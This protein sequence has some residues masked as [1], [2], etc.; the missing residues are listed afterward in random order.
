M[1]FESAADCNLE[2]KNGM[3]AVKQQAARKMV[4][5]VRKNATAQFNRTGKYAGGWI[6]EFEGDDVVVY[7]KGERDSLSHLLENGHVVIDRN[8]VLH[9]DWS[10]ADEHIKPAFEV[11]Q[12]VYLKAAEALIDDILNEW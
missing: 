1:N 2:L 6:Y 10:P 8:G 4:N 5:E 9:G 11:A 3:P 12:R 7:N